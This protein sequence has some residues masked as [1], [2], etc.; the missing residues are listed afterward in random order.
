[1]IINETKAMES[2]FNALAELGFDVND[3]AERSAVEIAKLCGQTSDRWTRNQRGKIESILKR[4]RN[5]SALV[6]SLKASGG[7]AY[8]GS[9]YQLIA[10]MQRYTSTEAPVLR[11]GKVVLSRNGIAR[12][13]QIERKLLPRQFEEL[14]VSRLGAATDFDEFVP[15]ADPELDPESTEFVEAEFCDEDPEKVS[16]ALVFQDKNPRHAMQHSAVL[17]DS[18]AIAQDTGETLANTTKFVSQKFEELGK[19]LGATAVQ[20]M[21]LGFQDSVNQGVTDLVNSVTEQ[22]PDTSTARRAVRKK[23]V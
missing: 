10:L 14:I 11:G 21:N 19:L 18:A 15:D 3:N 1:M 23:K 5:G 22:T 6:E 4:C 17:D 20:A 16:S 9:A 2:A 12:T 13:Q 7:K 8:S